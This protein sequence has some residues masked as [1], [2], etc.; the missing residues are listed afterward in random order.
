MKDVSTHLVC[1]L[2]HQFHHFHYIFCKTFCS[3]ASSKMDFCHTRHSL[4]SFHSPGH[5]EYSCRKL[6]LNGWKK[7]ERYLINYT[8]W[9]LIHDK[10]MVGWLF[11][12]IRF[13]LTKAVCVSSVSL[14]VFSTLFISRRMIFFQIARFSLFKN[15]HCTMTS[16]HF[17]QYSI[18]LFCYS[19]QSAPKQ[20]YIILFKSPRAYQ[21]Q[22]SL[23]VVLLFLNTTLFF[24]SPPKKTFQKIFDAA[25][26]VW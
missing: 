26:L 20:L 24:K 13:F 4:P 9:H 25:H 16:N 1:F 22:R 12:Y 3:L 21:D 5:C 11:L 17:V 7:N 2:H 15:S 8:V 18:Y 14:C 23:S 10:L 6:H 19:E